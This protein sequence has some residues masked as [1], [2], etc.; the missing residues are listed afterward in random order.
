MA[1]TR[2][3]SMKAK[4]TVYERYGKDFYREIGRIGGRNGHTGGFASNPE[5][6]REAGRKGGTISRRGPARPIMEARK[7]SSW[8][9]VGRAYKDGEHMNT[10]G[11]KCIVTNANKH[12]EVMGWATWRY[13]YQGHEFNVRLDSDPHIPLEDGYRQLPLDATKEDIKQAREDIANAIWWNYHDTPP[14]PQYLP[15]RRLEIEDGYIYEL[16]GA[17]GNAWFKVSNKLEEA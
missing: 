15:V 5:L 16:D 3:G 1:G 2:A 13:H 10:P 9:Q 14:A 6:A 17:Q 7:S 8:A 11:V 4:Q 12:I